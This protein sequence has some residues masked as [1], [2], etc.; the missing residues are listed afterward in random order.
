M[1]MRHGAVVMSDGYEPY[2]AI[3]QTHDLVD[4]RP[5]MQVVELFRLCVED[6]ILNCARRAR[7]P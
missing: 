3:A 1:G 5:H 2:N 7:P 6:G 4:Q